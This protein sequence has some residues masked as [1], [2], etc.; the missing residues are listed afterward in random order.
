MSVTWRTAEDGVRTWSAA[1]PAHQL[2][3]HRPL[4]PVA[5]G[6]D[7][8]FWN[9]DAAFELPAYSRRDAFLYDVVDRI[10]IVRRRRS[11]LLRGIIAAVRSRVRGG[12]SDAR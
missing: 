5:L 1:F 10:L 3:L 6:E 4:T 9:V 12:R 7:G 11:W 8:A 2:P